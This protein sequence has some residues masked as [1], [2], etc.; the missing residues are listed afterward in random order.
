M[1]FILDLRL[2]RPVDRS[3]L[4]ARVILT[5]NR[6][7][8]LRLI[9]VTLSLFLWSVRLVDIVRWRLCACMI[10]GE[11]VY[12]AREAIELGLV[13]I[14]GRLACTLS[15]E[16]SALVCMPACITASWVGSVRDAIVRVAETHAS[17]SVI[18]REPL[19]FAV[20]R[21]V[22]DVLQCNVSV[23]LLLDSSDEAITY[24]RSRFVAV[25]VQIARPSAVAAMSVCSTWSSE[26]E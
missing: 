15:G 11:P 12:F 7:R 9:G 13:I 4:V 8:I 14:V 19:Q 21:K 10:V 22:E 1:R 6:F 23:K 17:S 3:A 2:V 26:E 5:L 18:W 16:P 25:P 24:Y 20:K